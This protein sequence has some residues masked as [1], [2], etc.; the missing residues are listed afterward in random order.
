M[1]VMVSAA[2]VGNEQ[3]G[4]WVHFTLS[5]HMN[6]SLVNEMSSSFLPILSRKERF[7]VM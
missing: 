3:G 1:F 6:S 5:L 7:K 4:K 2:T